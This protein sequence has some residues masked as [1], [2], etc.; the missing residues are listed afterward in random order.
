[1]RADII[2]PLFDRL[3]TPADGWNFRP[4]YD[5]SLSDEAGRARLDGKPPSRPPPPPGRPVSVSLTRHQKGSGRESTRPTNK[6]D[7]EGGENG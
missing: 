2:L 3:E 4:H 5:S 1:M 7:S 6:P